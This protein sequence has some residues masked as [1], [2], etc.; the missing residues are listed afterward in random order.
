MVKQNIAKNAV[1]KRKKNTL[2]IQKNND[3]QPKVLTRQMHMY[4]VLFFLVILSNCICVV[5][6][7]KHIKVVADEEGVNYMS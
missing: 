1:S 3:T 2:M 5:L 4:C 7:S 6:D